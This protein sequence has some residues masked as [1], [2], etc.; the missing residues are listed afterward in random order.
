MKDTSATLNATVN[1]NG[2]ATSVYF[3]Y[4]TTTSYGFKTSPKNIGSGGNSTNVSVSVAGLAPSA[5]YH[6]R[7][8]AS[9]A[10]G[11]NHGSDQTFTTTG[12]PVVHTGPPTGV[13]SNGATLTGS[14]DP[15]G[16][17]T[18]WYF[19][20]GPIDRLRPRRRRR[21]ARAPAPPAR[22]RRRSAD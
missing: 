10:A 4:G 18:Q 7:V 16:H 6:V 11:S 9:S 2:Q 13:G 19:Q 1:P 15:N 22:S 8:V 12:P 3:E 21:A 20:Y 5:V 17:S 14:V